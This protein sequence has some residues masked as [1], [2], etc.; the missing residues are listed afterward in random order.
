MN[1]L[2]AATSVAGQVL[3]LDIGEVKAGMFAD[4]IA[5]DGDPTQRNFR[6]PPRQLRDE[7]RND[8]Q[9]VTRITC[10]DMP[11]P[12][13][14]SLDTSAFISGNSNAPF[15]SMRPIFIL[16]FFFVSRFAQSQSACP[17][18]QFQGTAT[19]LASPTS[20][21]HIVV[22][23]QLDGS[24]TAYELSNTS[25]YPI[26]H[27]T[28]NYAAALDACLPAR[29]SGPAIAPSTVNFGNP[30]GAGSQSAAYAIL[31]S[32]NYLSATANGSSLD[33]I[34]FDPSMHFVSE[35]M[36][37]QPF[38]SVLFAD[39]NNDGLPDIIGVNPGGVRVNG[40]YT[41]GS[42][43]VMLGSGQTSFQPPMTLTVS[44]SYSESVAA[45]DFNGDHNLDLAVTSAGAAPGEGQISIFLGNGDGTFQ[46]EQVPFPRISG[47]AIAASDLNGDGKPDLVFSTTTAAHNPQ[48]ITA[49]LGNGDGTFTTGS[50]YTVS[51]TVSIDIGDVNRDGFP[52]IVTSGVS[53]LFNDGRGNFPTRR[54]YLSNYAPVALFDFDGDGIVDIVAAAGNPLLSSAFGNFGISSGGTFA[55]LFGQG[56][57]KFAGEPLYQISGQ[58]IT[59]A[60][61][62]GDGYP[63]IVAADF[64]GNLAALI[65]SGDG[66]FTTGYQH[67]PQTGAGFPAALLAGDFNHDGNSDVAA[68]FDNGNNSLLQIFLGKGDGTFQAPTNAAL[69]TGANNFASADFNG[70]GNADLAV[71]LSGAP[72]SPN[73]IEILLG[74]GHGNFTMKGSYSSNGAPFSVVAGDFNGDG[75][76]DLAIA[77]QGVNN[78]SQN[79]SVSLL[80][81]NGDGT[82]IAGTATPFTSTINN[83]PFNIAA[84]DLN[85]DGKLDLV[86]TTGNGAPS[87][88]DILLGNGDGTFQSPVTSTVSTNASRGRRYQRRWNSRPDRGRRLQAQQRRWNISV[89]R[90]DPSQ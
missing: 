31:P 79:A 50:S 52:D 49:A 82:F 60:D 81:G 74:D 55:V 89:R 20:S 35:N 75:K 17:A 1:A 83:G 68:L 51:G 33:V 2:K 29:G 86:L 88:L 3:H 77:N 63:D 70:D 36:Y 18:V 58:V 40:V 78:T 69:P 9:T 15:I 27:T 7:R 5:V 41:N 56:N 85:R 80:L 16:F 34:E 26:L 84:A 6:H 65:G 39:M 73:A 54:D 44:A 8:L 23:R 21:S 53:I 42:I 59:T 38:T 10:G 64:A 32:G 67:A 19:A 28:P 12:V 71:A 72:G 66:S 90:H 22:A 45:I 61:F 46:S 30:P 13:K 4:L 11:Q 87:T 37:S 24:Y 47:W 62:N 76:L 43:A 14:T 25:P 48:A 57:G